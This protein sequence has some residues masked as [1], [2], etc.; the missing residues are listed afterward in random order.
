MPFYKSC[1]NSKRSG[2]L[3]RGAVTRKGS[4]G[5]PK[6]MECPAVLQAMLNPPPHTLD[7]LNRQIPLQ[8]RRSGGLYPGHLT[9]QIRK[10]P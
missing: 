9:A 2:K 8:G 5:L 7:N 4:L 3:S 6:Q 10:Y 1:L